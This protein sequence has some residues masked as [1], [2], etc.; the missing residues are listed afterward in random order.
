MK[1]IFRNLFKWSKNPSTTSS[2]DKSLEKLLTAEDRVEEL[3]PWDPPEQTED[4]Y[5]AKMIDE[6]RFL[7]KQ[8]NK[9]FNGD[10]F[11][12]DRFRRPKE[13]PKPRVTSS[14]PI[15][16]TGPTPGEKPSLDSIRKPQPRKF[17]P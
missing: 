4:P 11:S 16:Q 12:L 8:D 10:Y 14:E 15:P 5:V 17:S 6:L 3:D 1:N 13:A 2:V 7:N 9:R